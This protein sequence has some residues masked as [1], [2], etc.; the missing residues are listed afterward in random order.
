MAVGDFLPVTQT[1][2]LCCQV[3]GSHPDIGAEMLKSIS[4]TVRND[5]Q[6]ATC[7]VQLRAEESVI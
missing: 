2:R 3:Q 1:A 6:A 5:Y 4:E 7:F